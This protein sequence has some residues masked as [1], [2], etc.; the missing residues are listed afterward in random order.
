MPTVP[1]RDPS[2]PQ[3]VGAIPGSSE[4]PTTAAPAPSPSREG[5]GALGVIDEVRQLFNANYE[6]VLG[7]TGT[8]ESIGLSDAIAEAR[9]GCGNIV[10][11][12][13]RANS[14]GDD[15]SQGGSCVRVR[16][17]RD[18]DRFNVFASYTGG[19]QR[20]LCSTNGEVGNGLVLASAVASNDAGALANPLIGRVN[21]LDNVIIADDDLTAGGTIAEDAG[22]TVDFVLLEGSHVFN[23]LYCCGSQAAG[24]CLWG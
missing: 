22:V 23:P 3:T 9:A 21:G 5:D 17:G 14:I 13:L 6:D 11:G 16:N 4:T 8:H 1:Q 7:G 20:I 15:G 18:D 24:C 12:A 19:L 10:S 2:E